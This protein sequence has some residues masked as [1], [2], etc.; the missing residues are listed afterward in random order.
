VGVED[1]GRDEAEVPIFGLG[2]GQPSQLGRAPHDREQRRAEERKGRHQT[3]QPRQARA[4]ARHRRPGDAEA[5]LTEGREIA[6]A[7]A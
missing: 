5:K 7:H 3:G 1:R 2:V 4:D 6:T